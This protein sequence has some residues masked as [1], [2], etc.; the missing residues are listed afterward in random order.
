MKINDDEPL[1]RHTKYDWEECY[2]KVV[3]ETFVKDKVKNLIIKDRPD[4]QNEQ[5][6]V[7]IECTIAIDKRQI[8]AENLYCELTNNKTKNPE[9]CKERIEMLGGKITEYT[10]VQSG[11][12]TTGNIFRALNK[13][14]KKLNGDNYK[15]FNKNYLLIRDCI[16][17]PNEHIKGLQYLIAMIQSKYDR[18]FDTI[19]VLLN[20]K[21]IELNMI[22]Y[23]N[24]Y[25]EIS[26]NMQYELAQKARSIVVRYE[27]EGE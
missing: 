5:I 21:L 4:L 8:E 17:I 24:R 3:L 6:D 19:Y 2:A 23:T 12:D 25:F 11:S 7:G 22:D 9:K 14:L 18:E 16:Y 1:P 20:N 26:S 13:K 10:M 27:E 15:I